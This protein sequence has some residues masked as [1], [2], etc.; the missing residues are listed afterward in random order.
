MK[1][2]AIIL[3]I[4]LAF[5]SSGLLYCAEEEE[6]SKSSGL[7]G[8]LGGMLVGGLLG[9]GVG[10]AIGSASGHAGKGALIG[11]GVGAVG[12]TLLGAASDDA[13]KTKATEEEN[14]QKTPGKEKAK[15]RIV[16]EYDENGKLISEKEV[17]E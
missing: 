6:E 10:T 16:R 4:G 8:A 2:T 7:G 15:K 9:G 17:Q 14:A 1:I 13:K 5:L 3:I 11:A 12:G